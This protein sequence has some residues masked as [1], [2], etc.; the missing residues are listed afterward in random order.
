M[1]CIDCQAYAEE[2]RQCHRLPNIVEKIPYD[3][4]LE[5]KEKVV[6]VCPVEEKVKVEEA[7]VVEKAVESEP[8]VFEPKKRG[9]PMG[10]PRK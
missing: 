9:W 2:K 8:E 5:F 7:K 6:I 1:K 10:K 3:W 4:C